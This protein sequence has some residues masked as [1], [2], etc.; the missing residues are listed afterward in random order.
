MP[1][2]FDQYPVF[3]E[4]TKTLGSK[5]RL[6]YRYHTIIQQNASL[7]KGKRVVEIASHDGRWAFAAIRGA[8]AAHVTG[9]EPRQHLVDNANKTLPECGVDSSQFHFICG[10]GFEEAERM[11]RDGETYE[12]GMILGFLYHTARQYEIVHKV[13]E[14]GVKTL[15]VD[16]TVLADVTQPIVRLQMEGTGKE[17]M[18]H[19]GEKKVDLGG[20]PS[21]TAVN[22][23]L[24]AAGFRPSTIV[25]DRQAPENGAKDYRDGR[26]FTIVGTT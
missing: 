26:R 4:T 5:E 9:V 20:V 8:G 1:G 24:K 23:M 11:K 19:A 18:L 22:M 13:A 12:V 7:L 3:Y 6:N 17:S 21:I 10:D 2:F 25:A 16:T 14:L 15:I